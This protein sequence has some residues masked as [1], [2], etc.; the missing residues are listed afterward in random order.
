MGEKELFLLKKILFFLLC[1]VL[2]AATGIAARSSAENQG[3]ETLSIHAG[4]RG[5]VTFPHRQHQERIGDCMVCHSL[6]PQKPNSIEDL[7]A[8]GTLA[9]KQVM[10]KLCVKC[11]RDKRIKGEPSGPTSC[12]TC[13][14][15]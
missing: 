3:A 10:N 4:R 9:R 1:L 6:F 2:W 5:E 13:H 7:K 8:V 11:H 14:A 12:N 15:Q